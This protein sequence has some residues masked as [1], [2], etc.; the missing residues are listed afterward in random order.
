MSNPNEQARAIMETILQPAGTSPHTGLIGL[1]LMGRGM[2]LSL[3]RAGHT[4]HLVAHRKRDIAQELLAAGAHEAATP[5]A[6]AAA[7]EAIVLCLP[8]VETTEAVLF[9]PQGIV[10][11][12]PPGLLVIEC[13]TLLREAGRSFAQRLAA[14][15]V[16]F[17][18][19]PVT[20]GPTEAV[21]GRLNAL[22][23][24]APAAVER[25]LPV[26][27]AFCERTFR[28]GAS[29]Q[30][31]AAKLVN[32]FLA[33]NNLV[34]IAEAMHTAQS[35]GLNTQELLAAIAVSGGQNR[36]LD[37]LAPW[38]TGAGESRSRVTLATAHKDV[39]YYARLAES[40]ATLGPVAQQVERSLAQAL[41]NGLGE[42]FTPEYLR[43]I[44][45][46][47]AQGSSE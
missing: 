35:A 8:S 29:G 14:A 17:V 38:L 13:S 46:R 2:G 15:G 31:Y 21:A 9:G 26:L 32:N 37:G 34:A 16:D 1:G 6:L 42:Q 45:H 20:R 23:G 19:A 33:F 30:G 47:G 39:Q 10:W 7:C 27:Q 3:L 12:A 11:G 41:H 40:L 43:H 44:S 36:V 25:A 4:L 18:D 24:G 22:V 5:Q 28:F